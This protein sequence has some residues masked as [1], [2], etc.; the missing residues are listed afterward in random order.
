VTLIQTG[1]QPALPQPSRVHVVNNQS[2]YTV[3]LGSNANGLNV[4]VTAPQTP[5]PAPAPGF[6]VTPAHGLVTNQS[7][8]AATFTVKL[9]TQPTA[10]V[11]VQL[12]SSDTSAGQV[13]PA[14]LVFT[15]A[16]FDTAQQATVTGAI[17][18]TSSGNLPYSIQFSPAL[19]ADAAYAWMVAPPVSA[20]S[21]DTHL[22]TVS[23]ASPLVTIA[24]QQTASFTV[25]F[26]RAPTGPVTVALRSSDPAQGQPNPALLR[27]APGT[28]QMTV[29]VEGIATAASGFAPY[30]IL[31]SPSLSLADSSFNGLELPPVPLYNLGGATNLSTAPTVLSM[32]FSPAV[33]APGSRVVLV[34]H[35]V[36]TR[37]TDL[38]NARLDLSPGG[39]SLE[40]AAIAGAVLTWDGAGF[41]LP[42][43][44]AGSSL[45]VTIAARVTAAPGSRAGSSVLV[46]RPAADALS[47]RSGAWFTAAPLGLDLGGCSCRSGTQGTAL[48]WIGLSAAAWLA[49]RRRRSAF[50]PG[51][52]QLHDRRGVVPRQL[53]FALPAL[54]Q[55]VDAHH[56]DALLSLAHHHVGVELS[57]RRHLDGATLDVDAAAGLDP[58]RQGEARQIGLVRGPA[59]CEEHLA[60]RRG[61]LRRGGSGEAA[62]L[63]SA[64]LDRAPATLEG[65]GSAQRAHRDRALAVGGDEEVAAAAGGDHVA[66]LDLKSDRPLPGLDHRFDAPADA[67]AQGPGD[68]PA[69]AQ[70]AVVE[71]AHA[72]AVDGDLRF[73]VGARADGVGAEDAIAFARGGPAA[74]AALQLD[75]A[76]APEQ[77]GAG[78]R[79]GRAAA[80]HRRPARCRDGRSG[81]L[82]GGEKGDPRE[83]A[84]RRHHS[85][86]RSSYRAERG[87][88]ST[89]AR[90]RA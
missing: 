46:V 83:A 26:A 25:S 53:G 51:A 8:S 9:A 3:S 70:L 73:R 62:H 74:A 69:H 40:G 22:L 21:L 34:A 43:L 20:L 1:V 52:D 48:S 38:L 57:G 15:A 56:R 39:L 27:F 61:G 64:H 90:V 29:T 88:A 49:C 60:Q 24:G 67:R 76:G 72:H 55:R 36:N 33:A 77:H 5:A 6:I 82:A 45:D 78:V 19:S 66:V 37:A 30:S 54:P 81:G 47:E 18:G 10:N 41:L 17:R 71:D 75:A 13:T 2:G 68:G 79:L 35:V 28:T 4:S 59:H 32:T 58:S 80:G 63:A 85:H 11:I 65:D 7:G 42:V 12:S 31:F 44:A 14:S 89:A 84:Q 50:S 86:H 23:A 87:R 16:N